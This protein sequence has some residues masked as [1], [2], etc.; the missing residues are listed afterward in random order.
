MDSGNTKMRVAVMGAGAVGSY[1]GGMLAR[2][3]GDVTLI[4]RPAHVDAI[5]RDGLFMDTTSFRERVRVGAST[6]PAA[7]ADASLVLFCVKTLDT[8]TASSAIAPHLAPG[9]I[10]ASLQNGV[11]NIERIRAASGIDALPAVVF[12]AVALPEPGCVKHSGRGEL[13]IGEWNHRRGAAP[14]SSERCRRV[15]DLFQ[16][17]RVPC[18]ISED[19]EADLWGKFVLNCA[20][21]AVSAVAQATYGEAVREPHTREVMTRLIEETVAV[22]RA[23]GVHLPPTDFVQTGLAFLDTM[24]NATSSTAQDIAR[25]KPT[26]VDSLNGLVVRRGAE[27][28]VPTPV[29]FTVNALVKLLE[30]KNAAQRQQAQSGK[31]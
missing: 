5:R 8:E 24:I 23:A 7:V 16:S 18:R 15:A 22:G 31:S 21:N 2:A 4:G 27:L 25:G 10:V 13:A 28:G 11:D 26:E 20:G 19:I 3:G 17:A 12:V 14:P 29:N 9:A 6:D 1:F 30:M